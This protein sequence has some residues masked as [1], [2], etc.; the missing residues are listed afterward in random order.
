MKVSIKNMCIILNASQTT[1]SICAVPFT[2]R[3]GFPI[4]EK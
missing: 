4:F 3:D 2:L 1:L